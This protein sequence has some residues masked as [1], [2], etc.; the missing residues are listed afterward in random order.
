[1][2]SNSALFYSIVIPLILRYW[3]NS[4]TTVLLISMP[5]MLPYCISK[6]ARGD[7]SKLINYPTAMCMSFVYVIMPHV[8]VITLIYRT[9][10]CNGI[11]S[12]IRGKI[13]SVKPGGRVRE[14][15][16]R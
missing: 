12:H 6:P 8:R 3:T 15:R 2:E 14:S 16:T 1:M 4:A 9:L 10:S 7:F 11:H 13:V 5:S